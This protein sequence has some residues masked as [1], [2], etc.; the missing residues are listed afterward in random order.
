[1]SVTFW[2]PQAPRTRAMVP[3]TYQGCADDNRC[4]YCADGL[5]EQVTSPAPD[6]NLANGNA[7]VVLAVLGIPSADVELYGSLAGDD[8]ASTRRRIVR[9]LN[10]DLTVYERANDAGMGP[11]RGARVITQGLDTEGI[12]ER[13]TRLDAVLAYAQANGH[14][15]HWG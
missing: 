6:L 14:E 8:I 1:M 7:A 12:R 13:L 11:R 10:V 15:V 5:E 3:C 4:G 2:V 9:A